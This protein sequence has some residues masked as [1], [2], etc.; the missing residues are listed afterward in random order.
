MRRQKVS[1]ATPATSA[2]F[3]VAGNARLVKVYMSD[4]ITLWGTAIRKRRVPRPF[5]VGGKVRS[6][7]SR[8][9]RIGHLHIGQ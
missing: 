5:H 3:W 9:V 6:A 1:H 8:W 7:L 4:K 2:T